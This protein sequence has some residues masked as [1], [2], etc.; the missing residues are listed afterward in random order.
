[1]NKNALLLWMTKLI[2]IYGSLILLCAL[3][4]HYYVELISP[5][6]NG[7]I[8]KLAPQPYVT[9]LTIDRQQD[10]QVLALNVRLAEV[11]KIGNYVLPPGL[12]MSSTTLQGHA[13]QHLIMGS[14]DDL[15]NSQ[16]NPMQT[17]KSYLVHWMDFMNGGGRLAL[18]AAAALITL[19]L[20]HFLS[21]RWQSI[22]P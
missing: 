6:Y 21:H 8:H 18:S 22:N 7:E 14:I 4:G 11:L 20:Q 17:N 9:N 1:M 10:E 12:M 19:A 5:L 3:W 13:F 16:F 2:L 15:L